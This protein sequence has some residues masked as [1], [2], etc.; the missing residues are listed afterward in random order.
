MIK[1]REDE[2]IVGK[3]YYSENYNDR[4]NNNFILRLD[5]HSN[6][7]IY[8][9]DYMNNTHTKCF[10][11]GGGFKN[12]ITRLATIEEIH[13]FDQCVLANKYVEYEEAMKTF[14]Q[15]KPTIQDDPEL[16]NILIKLL[17]Q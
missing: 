8:I 17:T 11:L 10:D 2:L 14:N 1:L 15:V 5:T 9:S 7:C 3:Y 4:V 12:E 13:W 6:N 16:S